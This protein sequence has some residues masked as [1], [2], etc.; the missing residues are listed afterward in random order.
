MRRSVVE[1]VFAWI[2]WQPHILVTT[3]TTSL[4]SSNSPASLSSSGD[5]EIGP[6][7][8]EIKQRGSGQRP[9]NDRTLSITR[10]CPSNDKLGK[11]GN[12]RISRVTVSVTRSDP[13]IRAPPAKPG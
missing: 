4:A 11:M 6:S 13:A 1:L 9:K 3:L 5:F 12:D 2:Q 7:E 8:S 10:F